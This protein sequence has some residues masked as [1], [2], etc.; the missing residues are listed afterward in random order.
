MTEATMRVYKYKIIK[1]DYKD[2]IVKSFSD[3]TLMPSNAPVS[4]FDDEHEYIVSA[5]EIVR[6][7]ETTTSTVNFEQLKEFGYKGNIEDFRQGSSE[8]HRLLL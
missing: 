8:M 6:I 7:A 2:K 4:V 1:G 5:S 3:Y